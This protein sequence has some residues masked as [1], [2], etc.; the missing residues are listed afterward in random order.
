LLTL[1]AISAQFGT[2]PVQV[3]WGFLEGKSGSS[4]SL[5][6]PILPTIP[7]QDWSSSPHP[8]QVHKPNHLVYAVG[9][10]VY[11]PLFKPLEVKIPFGISVLQIKERMDLNPHRRVFLSEYLKI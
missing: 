2:P 4:L 11:V 9:T 6:V 3:V 7:G 1:V 5:I 8:S 10:T